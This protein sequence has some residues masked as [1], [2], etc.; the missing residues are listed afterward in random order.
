MIKSLFHFYKTLASFE[1][2]KDENLIAPDAIC[3]LQESGQI[4]VN[5]TYIGVDKREFEALKS[6]VEE[7][8]KRIPS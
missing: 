8:E 6:K 4:Y 1:E 5:S 2:H 3:F 7:L